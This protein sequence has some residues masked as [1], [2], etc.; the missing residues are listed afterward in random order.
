MTRFTAHLDACVLVPVTLADLLL[1]LAERDHYR[2]LWSPAILDEVEQAVTRIHPDLPAGMPQRR[3][4]FMDR[5][6]P[7][8]SVTGWQHLV[9]SVGL[10]DSDDEH[11]V[12]AAIVGRADVIVTHNTRDFPARVLDDL[13]I[14]V[15]TP[16]TFLLNQLDLAPGDVMGALRDQAGAT[17]CPPL[18]VEDILTRLHNAGAPTFASAARSQLWRL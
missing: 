8:A 13:D 9:G 15:Q 2:P 11:V 10:P 3:T 16:D 5:A 1:R 17:R 6:F 12:A 7:D 4:D 14:E 18:T